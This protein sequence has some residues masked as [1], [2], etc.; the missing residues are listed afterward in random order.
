MKKFTVIFSLLFL[1]GLVS[2]AQENK[3][4]TKEEKREEQYNQIK[5]LIQSVSYEFQGRFAYPLKGTQVDLL[6]NPNFLKISGENA[7]ASM[8]Y[9]GR[10]FSG[11]YSTSD[12]GINFDGSMENY[13]VKE[14][15]RKWRLTIKFKVKGKGDTYKCTLTV[16]SMENASLSITS[17]KRQSISYTGA[18]SELP[19]EN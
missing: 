18:V 4:Q 17:N 11:G 14:N 9:F 13:E 6:S 16:S 8:P 3:N 10:A 15:N 2:M 19:E 1:A 5:D 7:S 12:G